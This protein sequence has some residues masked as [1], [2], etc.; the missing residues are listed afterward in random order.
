MTWTFLKANSFYC[1]YICNKYILISTFQN[2]TLDLVSPPLS[3]TLWATVIT[4]TDSN[5]TKHGARLYYFPIHS[6]L[7]WIGLKRRHDGCT[8]KNVPICHFQKKCSYIFCKKKPVTS[9]RNY[10][11]AKVHVKGAVASPIFWTYSMRKAP[12]PTS[13]YN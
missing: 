12:S 2:R 6:Q 13:N 4:N 1:P 3:C 7:S 5:Y 10:D 8:L 11:E 9:N